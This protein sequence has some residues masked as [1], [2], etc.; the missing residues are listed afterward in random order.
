VVN[1]LDALK[2]SLAMA[3]KPAGTEAQAPKS[4]PQRRKA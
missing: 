1:I 2:K 3:K 4:K